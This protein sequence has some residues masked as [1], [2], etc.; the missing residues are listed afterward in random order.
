MENQN[1]AFFWLFDQ[2]F[3]SPFY[4]GML[5]FHAIQA[6]A[7]QDDIEPLGATI[8]ITVAAVVTVPYVAVQ[9]KGC[10]TNFRRGL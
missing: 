1:C 7:K 6:V 5:G 3:Q 9:L 4:E 2:Q 10:S 8:I